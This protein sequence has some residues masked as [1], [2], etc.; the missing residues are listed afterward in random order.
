MPPARADRGAPG[1]GLGLVL[2]IQLLDLAAQVVQ[3]VLGLHQRQAPLE[4]TARGASCA[5]PAVLPDLPTTLD[6]W[7]SSGERL[8][9]RL[10]EATPEKIASVSSFVSETGEDAALRKATYEESIG[11][12]EGITSDMFG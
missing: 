9:A 1:L 10:A 11:W 12:Y 8:T 4:L 6:D 7:R 2:R 5:D 3:G